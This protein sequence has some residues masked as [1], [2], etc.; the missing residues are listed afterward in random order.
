MATSLESNLILPAAEVLIQVGA[1]LKGRKEIPVPVPRLTMSV[2]V[3][4][5]VS[6]ALENQNDQLMLLPPETPKAHKAIR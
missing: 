4:I 2:K 5:T 3:I 6:S 1:H